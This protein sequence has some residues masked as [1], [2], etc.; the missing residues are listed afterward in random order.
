MNLLLALPVL[1]LGV[2]QFCCYWTSDFKMIRI[3]IVAI[4]RAAPI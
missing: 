1:A 4:R 2:G 3:Q